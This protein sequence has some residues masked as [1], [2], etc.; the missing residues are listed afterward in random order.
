MGNR[1]AC[2]LLAFLLVTSRVRAE[3]PATATADGVDAQIS[4]IEAMKPPEM[5]QTKLDD[6]P[7]RESFEARAQ[8]FSKDRA[9]KINALYARFPQ[10][11][12][13]KKLMLDRWV[14]LA[15]FGENETVIKETTPILTAT[16]DPAERNDLLYVRAEAFVWPH[17]FPTQ[18]TQ[19]VD[20]FLKAA[21]TDVR[22]GELLFFL[23]D[24]ETNPQKRAQIYRRAAAD[25][26]AT[27]VYAGIAKGKALQADAISKPLELSFNDLATG[28]PVSVQKDLQGKIVVIIFWATWCGPCKAELPEEKQLYAAYKDRGVEFIGVSLDEPEK[29]GGLKALKG[30]LAE[31]PIPWPQYYQGNGVNSEFSSRFG[32]IA[33]PQIFVIDRHG[34]LATIAD[35]RLGTALREAMDAK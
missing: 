6:M 5:D 28:K 11:A 27:S 21:P 31:N 10:D 13:V 32:V 15:R 4:Q 16:V 25:V 18:A 24:G 29:D 2:V 1:R 19:A 9:E 12:R 7:Y 34:K 17:T 8:M 33:I 22:G 30:Y 20:E 26:Y 14:E 23:A 35:G 3:A